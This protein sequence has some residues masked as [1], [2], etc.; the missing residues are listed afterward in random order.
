MGTTELCKSA[1]GSVIV[2]P[3]EEERGGGKEERTSRAGEEESRRAGDEEWRGRKAQSNL[4][5]HC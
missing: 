2:R 1:F 3:G 4:V 5:R